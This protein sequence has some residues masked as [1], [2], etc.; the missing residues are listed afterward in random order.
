ME[1]SDDGGTLDMYSSTLT[2]YATKVEYGKG[3]IPL[4][5]VYNSEGIPLVPFS[6]GTTGYE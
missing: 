2:S 6:A 5:S 1:I 3:D 4:L